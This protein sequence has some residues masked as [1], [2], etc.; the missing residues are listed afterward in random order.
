MTTP[1]SKNTVVPTTK[2]VIPNAQPAFFSPN[3]PIIVCA[4][5]CAPPDTSKIPPNIDPSPISRT[6]PCSVFPAPYSTVSISVVTGIPEPKPIANADINKLKTGCSL[7]FKI[8]IKRMAIPAMAEMIS[9]TGSA[10]KTAS[11][12][13]SPHFYFSGEMIYFPFA[14]NSGFARISARSS[15]LSTA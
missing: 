12:I 3:F 8:R 1:A 11:V 2:P 14:R 4:T 5:C 6:I 9:R 13:R 15:R 7:H 10:A